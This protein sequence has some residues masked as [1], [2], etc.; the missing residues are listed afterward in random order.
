MP[1]N[2]IIKPLA[3]QEIKEALQWYEDQNKT[4]SHRLYKEIED[5]FEKLK[6][7]PE[8]YQKRYKEIRILF[9]NIF[10]YGFYYTIDKTIVNIHAFL[11]TKQD[12]QRINTRI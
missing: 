5:K 10:P 6:K 1:Y 3:E 11:R 4:L 12:P 8:H 2:L 7:T 9:L